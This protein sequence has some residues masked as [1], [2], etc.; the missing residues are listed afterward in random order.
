MRITGGL[1]GG[2]MLKVPRSGV[3][4][5]QER[6]REAVFSA[7]GDRAHHADV[8][9]LFAGTGAL[10]LEAWSRG[11]RS[12]RWIERNAEA[13]RILRQNVTTLCGAEMALACIRS[14]VFTYLKRPDAA[15]C[16]FILADPPYERHD[17]AVDASRLMAQLS[18]GGHVKPGGYLILEQR[19][20]QPVQE[21]AGWT[22]RKDKTYGDTRVLFYQWSLSVP[23]A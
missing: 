16:D 17:E 12:V 14:E 11:A 15:A 10:G 23:E 20:A 4:P 2:R 9:D 19:T 3:R 22:L 18:A 8:L 1:L 21:Q 5:T 13:F 6:V 7:L